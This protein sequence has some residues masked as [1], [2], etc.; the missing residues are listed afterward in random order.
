MLLINYMDQP[1][2]LFKETLNIL[3]DILIIKMDKLEYKDLPKIQ[4]EL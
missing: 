2:E 4:L 3:L 1:E